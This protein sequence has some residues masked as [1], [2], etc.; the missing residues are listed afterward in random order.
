MIDLIIPNLIL[1]KSLMRCIGIYDAKS[2]C[3]VAM[4][5]TLKNVIP[6]DTHCIVIH[7]AVMTLRAVASRDV[8]GVTGVT[9]DDRHRFLQGGWVT[10]YTEVCPVTHLH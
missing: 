8:G 10:V 9:L 5:T 6:L 4:D 3:S 7:E 2:V 1:K